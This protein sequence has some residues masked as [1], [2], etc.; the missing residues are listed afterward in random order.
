MPEAWTGLRPEERPY[1]G[2]AWFYAEYRDRPSPEF[3]EALAR[4]L[5]WSSSDRIL[6]LGAG[7]AHVSLLLAPFVGEV[8]AMDPEPDMLEEGRRR[9]QA[10]GI[11]NVSFIV[12]GS[13]DLPSLTPNLGAVKA[14][15]ISQA[16][17]WVGD[18]DGL[19][20][21]LDRLLA[22][23]GAIA[24]VGFVKDPDPNRIWL[25]RPPWNAVEAIRMRY[26]AAAP[27]GP[28]PRGR[29]DP[30][31]DI[32]ARSAFSEVE[33]L[34]HEYETVIHP[35]VEAAI[36]YQYTLSNVLAQ[37]GDRRTAFE[38]EARSALVGADTSPIHVTLTDSALVGRR[39]AV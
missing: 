15:A 34:T 28:H 8:I 13:D 33:L 35:S 23:G 17:H 1:A 2:T 9:A 32:L 5:G 6:D 24:L 38:A 20:R 37:L 26:L 31:P 30:F 16:F 14:A 18:K 22:P 39:P 36:G 3:A 12:G 27:D 29:H 11:D 7:P 21:D 25:D 19:L 4:T 10:A